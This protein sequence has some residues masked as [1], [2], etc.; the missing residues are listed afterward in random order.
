MRTEVIAPQE[1]RIECQ[2][3]AYHR[4]LARASAR[5]LLLFCKEHRRAHLI[6]WEEIAL[7]QQEFRPV[8][9]RAEQ[10]G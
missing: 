2:E 8:V 5:G 6:T 3:G 10:V 9:V 1:R 4:L 7:L